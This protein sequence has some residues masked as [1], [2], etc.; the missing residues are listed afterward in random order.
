MR[1]HEFNTYFCLR[2]EKQNAKFWTNIRVSSCVRNLLRS[3][4]KQFLPN[5]PSTAEM[6]II[7]SS[8]ITIRFIIT[9]NDFKCIFIRRWFLA[10]PFAALMLAIE[11]FRKYCIRKE[12]FGGWFKML[13]Y[14]QLD[15]V[16][17][18][19]IKTCLTKRVYSMFCHTLIPQIQFLL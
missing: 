7:N 15:E 18:K 8:L 11:E 3:W 2:Y 19:I 13:T 4:D 12:L 10:V 1:L 14:Y 9:V 6:V 17:F 5:L 16:L